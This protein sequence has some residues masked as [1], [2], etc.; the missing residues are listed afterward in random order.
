MSV[1]MKLMMERINDEGVTIRYQNG[2]KKTNGDI[3]SLLMLKR[4]IHSS[5]ST[6]H[7][8]NNTTNSRKM[9]LS[10]SM[11]ALKTPSYTM[12]YIL[13]YYSQIKS[14]KIITSKKVTKTY[15]FVVEKI[16]NNEGSDYYYNHN[17]AMHVIAFI[18]R[19]CKHSKGIL[20]GKPFL[21]SLRQKAQLSVAF[22]IL[23]KETEL[24]KYTKVVEIVARKNGKSTLASA[25]LD[26]TWWLL[27]M[28]AVQKYMQ[29]QPSE[30][31]LR[32]FGMKPKRMVN[33]SPS[34]K[35]TN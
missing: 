23:S 30:T 14:K 8:S 11:M 19:Y 25:W 32:L 31:K 21:L 9:I 29:S 1:Q 26:F 24:R 17:R 6:Q 4:T 3:K 34:L 16:I 27:T 10:L 20:A 5:S 13:D 18:E 22:G 7:G 2:E 28:K 35:K 12:N 33:K 15:Q